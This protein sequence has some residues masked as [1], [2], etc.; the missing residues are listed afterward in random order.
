MTAASTRTAAA[1]APPRRSWRRRRARR[2]ATSRSRRASSRLPFLRWLLLY[3]RGLATDTTLMTAIDTG[4]Q[5][6]QMPGADGTGNRDHPPTAGPPQQVHSAEPPP[7]RPNP[8]TLSGILPRRRSCRIGIDRCPCWSRSRRLR[9]KQR[10]GP[11]SHAPAAARDRLPVQRRRMRA[12]GGMPVQ[13][14]R[15]EHHRLATGACVDATPAH[16]TGCP[17]PRQPRPVVS[18]TVA[19]RA[20]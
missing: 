13:I 12:A 7:R 17:L 20:R 1:T 6:R 3:D 2:R 15:M 8:V 14:H 10:G 4:Q 19:S 11:V 18:T 9:A 16:G 5:R